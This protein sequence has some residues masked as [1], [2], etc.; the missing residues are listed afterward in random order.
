MEPDE[1]KRWKTRKCITV[2]ILLDEL[3]DR[4]KQTCI[5]RGKTRTWIKRR[6]E[7]GYFNNIVRELRAKDTAAYR[8]MMRM[9][10]EDFKTILNVIEPFIT[11]RQVTW[12]GH[13]VIAAAERLTLTIRFMATGETYRSMCFQFRISVSAISYI[14]KQVCKAIYDHLGPEYL[15]VPETREE[16]L[17]I[18][19]RFEEKWNYPNCLGAIDGKYNV[20]CYAVTPECRFPLL[21]L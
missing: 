14:V 7:K 5:S 18:A 6:N 21:Q 17:D 4:E 20:Y 12:G 2:A 10:Y 9:C 15:K 1:W 13:K 19:A 3:D 16:W 11:P 8:D